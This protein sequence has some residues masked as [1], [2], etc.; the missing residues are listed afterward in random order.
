MTGRPHSH[1]AQGS[2]IPKGCPGSALASRPVH[3][4]PFRPRVCNI[5]FS[6]QTLCLWRRCRNGWPGGG[7]LGAWGLQFQ[8]S[9]GNHLALVFPPGKWDRG[10]AQTSSRGSLE[11]P[12]PKGPGSDQGHTKPSGVHSQSRA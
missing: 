3:P 8:L 5:S 7:G 6:G 2:R 4:C 9:V 12:M 1:W 10:F 11:D